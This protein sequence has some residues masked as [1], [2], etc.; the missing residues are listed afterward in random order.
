MAARPQD[1]VGCPPLFFA[2]ANSRIGT[3]VGRAPPDLRRWVSVPIAYSAN[4]LM[5]TRLLCSTRSTIRP[6]KLCVLR[7]LGT[8]ASPRWRLLPP[9]L[10]CRAVGSRRGR[11]RVHAAPSLRQCGGR[12]RWTA[13]QLTTGACARFAAA[14]RLCDRRSSRRV[15]GE[16]PRALNPQAWWFF[17][18]ARGE[19]SSTRAGGFAYWRR[20]S[21]ASPNH[22]SSR[23]GAFGIGRSRRSRLRA[24]APGG[25]GA[26]G[27]PDPRAAFHLLI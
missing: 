11:G 26:S 23:S 6:Y 19:V 5:G 8:G 10:L 9:G 13:F 16:G 2:P 17:S 14:A 3:S 1:K 7:M 24:P 18:Q 4:T 22:R 15:H 25:G 12:L 27:A 20:G 21:R